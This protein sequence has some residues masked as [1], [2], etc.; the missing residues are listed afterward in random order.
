M[1][2]SS[3]FAS[4]RNAD[5]PRPSTATRSR[6][7]RRRP[8][9]ASLSR[10]RARSGAEFGIVFLSPTEEG[11]AMIK[12]ATAVFLIAAILSVDPAKAAVTNP[13]NPIHFGAWIGDAYT[14]DQSGTFSHCAASA[15]Y[16]SGITMAVSVDRNY[17]WALGFLSKAWS[18]TPGTEIPITLV[19][20]QTEPLSVTGIITNSSP[21]IV[22]V[23]MPDNSVIINRFREAHLLTALAKGQYFRF[24]LNGTSALLP[25]LA[26]CVRTELTI[27]HTGPAPA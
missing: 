18:L 12:V 11:F 26:S 24:S 1:C 5:F 22:R 8:S 25:M 4:A 14:N 9:S 16:K 15:G 2:R 21:P 13:P 23:A 19:F 20:D 7:R 3:S 10:R 27:E 6:S 17:N